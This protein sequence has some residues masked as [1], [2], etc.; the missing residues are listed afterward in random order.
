MN[1]AV[2]PATEAED[3]GVD[4][5]AIDSLSLTSSSFAGGDK[6][7]AAGGRADTFEVLLPPFSSFLVSAKIFVSLH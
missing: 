7:M 4:D 3:R 2:G 5:D 1:R 6:E